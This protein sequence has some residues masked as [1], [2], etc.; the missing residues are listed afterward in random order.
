MPRNAMLVQL[1]ARIKKLRL[2]KDIS[3]TVMA[4]YAGI[5]RQHLSNVEHGKIR[6]VRAGP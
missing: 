6:A 2:S 3:I 1:G 5:S 4:A